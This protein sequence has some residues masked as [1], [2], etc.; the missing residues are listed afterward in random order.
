MQAREAY[1]SSLTV[2]KVIKFTSSYRKT[3]S[4]NLFT[5]D[6]SSGGHDM[7]K[8][9]VVFVLSVLG[10]LSVITN[11]THG[12]SQEGKAVVHPASASEVISVTVT[13]LYKRKHGPDSE[14][15]IAQA[16]GF[17]TDTCDVVTT[18]DVVKKYEERQ[19]WSNVKQRVDIVVNGKPYP[20]KFR[21]I[22][23]YPLGL[24]LAC[25]DFESPYLH[26]ELKIP[27]LS[28]DRD[29]FGPS[30][31]SYD[32]KEIAK[33]N[34]G[35]PFLNKQGEISAV[36]TGSDRGQLEFACAEDIRAFLRIAAGVA[37]WP[38]LY[39]RPLATI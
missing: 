35:T 11:P 18:F 1:T 6:E 29:A 26:A 30:S 8:R 28:L 13:D 14:V 16:A 10:M 2:R 20:A 22:G 5:E 34:P 37:P 7:N 17:P 19:N 25:I 36:L 4:N 21:D 31:L 3:S 23:F 39:R 24:N 9:G 38:T 32:N 27:V 12:H 15:V 33:S